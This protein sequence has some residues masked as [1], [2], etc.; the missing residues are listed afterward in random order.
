MK[1]EENQ[2][3]IN[4][5]LVVTMLEKILIP[6]ASF[7][8]LFAC[9]FCLVSG[10]GLFLLCMFHWVLFCFLLFFVFVYYFIIVCLISVLLS[11]FCLF[12]F[13]FVCSLFLF[14]PL[15]LLRK[16]ELL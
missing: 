12:G 6:R 2:E 13:L 11:C 4:L 16:E 15:V 14:I 9:L 1:A 7:L 3:R 5:M 10:K 8:C